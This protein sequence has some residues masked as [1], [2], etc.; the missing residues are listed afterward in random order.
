MTKISLM[1]M[2]LCLFATSFSQTDHKKQPALGV[3]FA[4][5]DFNTA[6]TLRNAGLSK[7]LNTKEWKKT[8]SMGTGLAVSYLQG[9]TNNLDL[10]IIGT[11]TFVDYPVPGK[12]PGASENLLL[13]LAA[14]ANLK[15]LSD[16]Y[17]I[18]PFLTFGAGA[19]KYKGYYGA[20]T[21]LGLG[22]QVNIFNEAYLLIN[23]QYRIPI[24]ENV[25]YHL[26]HS[27]GIAGN[28]GSKKE[29]KMAALPAIPSGSGMLAGNSN[30]NR[31]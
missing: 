15:L 21:P 18:T 7:V 6:K 13:E 3:Y 9:L 5:D 26:Y 10:A 16:N 17:G 23:S 22:L 24:T 25:A 30:K 2:A 31:N 4:F 8:K 29:P 28:I 1:F 11:G 20:F 12:A 19:S 14:T 27:I